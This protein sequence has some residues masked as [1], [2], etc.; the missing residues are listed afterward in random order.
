MSSDVQSICC[1]CG[2]AR[3]AS[4]GHLPLH[5]LLHCQEDEEIGPGLFQMLGLEQVDSTGQLVCEIC[6]NRIISFK[7]FV[8]NCRR[9]RCLKKTIQ[10][11]GPKPENKTPST[12]TEPND[13][14]ELD[15]SISNSNEDTCLN[16]DFLD[17]L[18]DS[19]TFK[20]DSGNGGLQYQNT[21][22]NVVS[23]VPNCIRPCISNSES[24][25]LLS[26]PDICLNVPVSQNQSEPSV[27]S[28]VHTTVTSNIHL[29]SEAHQHIHATGD[30]TSQG[31]KGSSS[32]EPFGKV[33]SQQLS[34]FNDIYLE[35]DPE[36]STSETSMP[37]IENSTQDTVNKQVPV[38]V[39]EKVDLAHLQLVSENVHSSVTFPPGTV[40]LQKPGGGT[41]YILPDGTTLDVAQEESPVSRFSISDKDGV[42]AQSQKYVH[43]QQ[44]SQ[45][46]SPHTLMKTFLAPIGQNSDPTDRTRIF[47][48][49]VNA[50]KPYETQDDPTKVQAQSLNTLTQLQKLTTGKTKTGNQ[51]QRTRRAQN[52]IDLTYAVQGQALVHKCQIGEPMKLLTPPAVN[53]KGQLAIP[54]LT[55]PA[56]LPVLPILLPKTGSPVWDYRCPKCKILFVNNTD[57]QSH[58]K[59]HA[60]IEHCPVC[61]RPFISTEDLYQ[62]LRDG[63]PAH[64]CN[65][66]QCNY[67]SGKV[68]AVKNHM[69]L[70]S[71]KKNYHVSNVNRIYAVIIVVDNM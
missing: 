40:I 11:E 47:Y 28:S 51:R 38:N 14:A 42:I 8:L 45:P 32:N 22:H 70:H 19:A 37:T 71:Q 4:T 66:D 59:I 31:F 55:K 60:D 52:L 41:V 7:G 24:L 61:Q 6:C 58:V 54:R 63:H 68:Y 3:R 34:Q 25:R 33:Y 48:S 56:R 18:L 10:N 17:N 64:I 36:E 23:P 50:R 20:G 13:G 16:S 62:H 39:S 30:I 67:Y 29:A 49:E 69:N 9:Q 35:R 27:L 2:E 57:L 5:S 43:K 21:S 12:S 26:P 44:N 53:R 46:T 15:I 1:L 65:I